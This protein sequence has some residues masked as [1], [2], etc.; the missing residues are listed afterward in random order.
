MCHAHFK[1][2]DLACYNT[3]LKARFQIVTNANKTALNF[4]LQLVFGYA[5]LLY[6]HAYF[7]II[8]SRHFELLLQAFQI[9]ANLSNR[10]R[11]TKSLGYVVTT[12]ALKLFINESLNVNFLPLFQ[13]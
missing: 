9:L 11:K 4:S 1:P 2:N 5:Y 10:I 8:R 6:G 13:P 3:S 7:L 12:E